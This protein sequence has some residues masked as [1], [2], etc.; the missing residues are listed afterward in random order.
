MT[1]IS[2]LSDLHLET[3][4]QELPGGEVLILA[5]DICEYRTFSNQFHSTKSHPHVPGKLNAYD[6]FYHE[7][8]KYEKVFYVL[9]NHEHYHHGLHRT[10]TDLELIL[11]KNIT[12]LENDMVEYNGIV[13]MG[14]TLWTDLNK[15]DPLTAYHL[16]SPMGMNDFRLIQNHYPATGLYH[17]LTP[18]FT[19]KL[20]H[21]TTAYFKTI[22]ELN[23]DKPVVMIT[24]H[25]PSFAS[26]REPYIN[27]TT[28][29]GGYASNMDDFIMDHA[30][31]KVA[32][33]GHMHT[34]VDYMMNTARILSNPRGYIGQEDTS[35]FNPAAM[36]EL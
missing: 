33:H 8:A 9:G 18:E 20:H 22:L 14:A 7:C 4:Y 15:G 27:D 32:I 30:N 3:G 13:F 31:I 16:K 23:R 25:A 2:F 28:L 12:L 36:F 5:G 26:V 6:F 19:A 34:P 35:K 21:K 24:H 11:P 29:N 1:S 17:K 10:R